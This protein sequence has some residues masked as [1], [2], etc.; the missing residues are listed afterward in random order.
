VKPK[1]YEFQAEARQL[2]DLVV[3][4][5][6]SH[7]EV[8]L[9]ELVSNASDALDK[10]RFAALTDERLAPLA[11]DLSIR[12]ATRTEPRTLIVEDD[13]IG[14]NKDELVQNLGSIASSGTRRFL[15]A[16]AKEGRGDVPSLIGRFGVGFYAVFMV[17]R[18]VVVETRKAGEDAAWRWTSTGD[19]TY[20]V[21]SCEK[22]E[23][24]TRI[25]LELSDVDAEG[26]GAEKD[27]A[28]DYTQEWVLRD[29]IRR[30]SDFVEYPIRMEVERADE[31]GATKRE[32]VTLNSMRPLWSRPKEDVK[33]HEYVEFYKHLARD[34]QEPLETIHFK[35]EG[36]SEYAALLFLPK[37]A[38][39]SLFEPSAAKSNVHLYVRRVFI[40]EAVEEL[41]PLWLRFVV[42]VVDSADLPLNVSRETLQHTRQLGR[43]KTRIT[44]KVTEALA[45]V[46]T[47]RRADYEAFWGEFGPIVKEG[48]YFEDDV[49]AELAAAC[50]FR[51]THSDGWTTLGEYLARKP[52][53]Q[54]SILVLAG[55][56]LVALR[57][58]P[59]LEAAR[60]RGQEVLLLDDHVDE[61]WLTR[62]ESFEGCDLVALHKGDAALGDDAQRAALEDR[63]K[64][65]AELFAALKGV[66]GQEELEVGY[67]ARLVESPAV[68][69][70]EE[71]G[72]SPHVE[73]ALRASGQAGGRTARR[74]FELNPDHPVVAGLEE[75]RSKDRERFERHVKLLH[76]QA[77][78][79]EG[80]PLPDP[81]AF[82]KLVVEL[83]GKG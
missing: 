36:T 30:Y 56:D 70:T 67:S 15:E 22:P 73:R 29:V 55:P 8:F 34:W 27:G 1:T 50:L 83:L 79:A 45:K 48:L 74:R 18:R 52:A 2:L 49:R 7:A 82:S 23:H 81:A 40:G 9:R 13:G 64:S 19:G 3:H 39:K 51:T 43:I 4:S 75:L 59:H 42:G 35:A 71:G 61:F 69:V 65:S 5:L 33:P 72:A 54:K 41:V 37:S 63:E 31:A 32:T 10:L 44:R 57:G 20:T 21:E 26:D 24:G 58:S 77:L 53:D 47:E 6:Y 68:L 76:G 17:A 12:L 25:T 16:A 78:L 14:M 28:K 80:S 46:C 11:K 38:K 62:L 66:L 60:K